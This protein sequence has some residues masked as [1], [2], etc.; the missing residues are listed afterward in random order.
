M[1]ALQMAPD[2][3]GAI[4][5]RKVKNM[6]QLKKLV[7]GVLMWMKL[8]LH[9]AYRDKEL[10]ARLKQ[11]LGDD[12]FIPNLKHLGVWDDLINYCADEV[13]VLGK[14]MQAYF[15]KY[16]L[17]EVLGKAYPNIHGRFERR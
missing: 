6:E 4:I 14:E 12:F 11:L 3:V 15:E 10:K 13:R 7:P 17:G 16:N 5:S 8:S 2:G 9:V 1:F